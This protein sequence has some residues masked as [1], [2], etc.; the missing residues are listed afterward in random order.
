MKYYLFVALFLFLLSCQDKKTDIPQFFT[1]GDIHYA[2]RKLLEVSMEDI[3]NPPVATRVFCYP[4]LAAYEIF[5]HKTGYSPINDI[6]PGSITN[7][8]PQNHHIDYSIAAL[9]AFTIIGKQVVFSEHLMDS[10]YLHWMK[11]TQQTDAKILR[12]SIQYAEKM[13]AQISDF[14]D[15]DNYAKVKSDDFHTL[16]ESDSS[17]VLTPP[18]F[19]QPLEPNWKNLRPLVVGNV[20]TLAYIPKPRFSS[21]PDSDFYKAALDVYEFSKNP[22][23][24]PYQDIA[25]HWDCNPNEY[26]NRGHSTYF[27]HKLSPPAH[28]VN[29]TKIICQKNNAGFDQAV[30]AYAMVTSAIFDGMIACWHIKYTED[31]IRPVTYINRYIDPSWQPFIQTP[32]FPEFTSGH[33]T[34]S[35]A[36]SQVLA[37]LFPL[38]P[39]DDDTEVEFGLPVRSY[40]DVVQAGLEASN[41][42]FYGGI[43][44]QFGV[45]NGLEQGKNIGNM[46]VNKW[47]Q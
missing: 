43:H 3:F 12:Q 9:V 34:V 36:G 28:W 8:K 35:G 4:N 24:K 10:L 16:R 38:T 14:I 32:P 37:S 25:L 33:S 47:N 46:V 5:S 40:N 15:N 26:V 18:T 22:D 44:Y 20:D 23:L 17:W 13:A 42:R 19:E 7:I 21:D 45:D 11:K 27:I 30:K 39:F 2:N 31:L 29:I 1:A 41:S 6:Y